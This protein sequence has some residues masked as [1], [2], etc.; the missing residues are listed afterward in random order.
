VTVDDR[1]SKGEPDLALRPDATSGH[2]PP[3]PPSPELL[4]AVAQTQPVRTRRPARTWLGIALVSLAWVVSL[5]TW[6][7]G[8][9]RDL[10]SIPLAPL[11][12][13]ALA[14]I[15]TFGIH[16]AAALIPAAGQVLPAGHR[17]AR[18]SILLSVIAVPIGLLAGLHIHGDLAATVHPHRLWRSG[19]ACL[20]SGFSVAALPAILGGFSL[21][22]IIP[23]GAWRPALAVGAAGGVLAGLALQFHCPISQLAH[24]GFAHGAAMVLPALFLALLG[25]RMLSR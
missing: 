5:V 11:I 20:A 18:V 2:R 22:R 25:T 17:S 19:L 14:S 9:R 15:A 10:G 8:L 6:V 3:P 13:F 16:L 7:I 24:V 1:T 21:R 4:A 12:L 23:V